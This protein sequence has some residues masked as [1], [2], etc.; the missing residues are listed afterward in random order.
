MGGIKITEKQARML[1]ALD[2]SRVMKITKEQFG[3]ILEMENME[4][5]ISASSQIKKDFAKGMSKAPKETKLDF[6]K[7]LNSKIK[8]GQL[9]E[10]FVNELYSLN[11]GETGEYNKLIK[12]LEVIGVVENRRLRKEAFGGDKNRAKDIMECGL[13]EMCGDGD[14]YSAIKE[15]ETSIDLAKKYEGDDFYKVMVEKWF[16]DNKNY[17][18]SGNYAYVKNA[19]DSGDFKGAYKAMIQ[20]RQMAPI[21]EVENG[22]E[23]VGMDIVNHPPFNDL[24][25]TR[26]DVDWN[27]RG[28]VHIPSVE[29]GDAM[30][31]VVAKDDITGRELTLKDGTSK[32]VD[33][34][35]EKFNQRFGEEPTFVLDPT[36]EWY[37]RV[38]IIN[39]KF[40]EWQDKYTTG[41]ADFLDKSRDMGQSTDE[42]MGAANAGQ[43]TGALGMGDAH[44]KSNVPDELGNIIEE[45]ELDESTD[46]GSVGGQYATSG[47]P[48]SKFMGTKGK[49]GK[50]RVSK[51]SKLTKGYS[52]V[53][54]K[55]EENYLS[56][57]LPQEVDNILFTMKSVLDID[58]E[59]IH[60]FINTYIENPEI[61]EE[62]M[63]VFG[64]LRSKGVIKGAE[65][66]AEFIEFITSMG[67]EEKEVADELQV[68]ED[69]KTETQWEGGSFVQPKEKCKKFPYCN[70]G[71]DAIETKKTK[72]SVISADALYQEVALKT[73]RSISEVKDIIDKRK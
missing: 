51:G 54:G 1:E 63:E 53:R 56:N 37:G 38:K 2:T 57:K 18:P 26:D 21:H 52:L 13:Y 17:Q 32:K 20:M 50:A 5:A 64:K 16:E 72:T 42:A 59:I 24:P 36:A 19:Y 25:E 46:T 31:Q 40:V 22:G 35:I 49:K 47:F 70:Q 61:H 66:A 67:E 3:K 7:N 10:S 34:Y 15:I 69:A 41:K 27:F 58:N 68:N 4:E 62:F 71:P 73:G 8:E 12:L 48:A 65:E 29:D 44:F 28:N 33:G 45:E 60:E 14:E 6:K 23:I 55:L 30:E 11:E 39:P 43:Y 9:W